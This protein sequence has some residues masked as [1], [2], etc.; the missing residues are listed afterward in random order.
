MNTIIWSVALIV[1]LIASVMSF[2]AA[3]KNWKANKK[4][5][6]G[7]YLA[8]FILSIGGV[9]RSLAFLWNT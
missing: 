3:L 7:V 5:Q 2:I 9:I 6:A 8:V 1:C 4:Q